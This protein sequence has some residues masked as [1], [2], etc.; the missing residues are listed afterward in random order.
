MTARILIIENHPDNQKLMGYLL[1]KS[2]YRVLFADSGEEGI[3][4]ALRE[5]F[6]LIL[7]DIRM[8]GMDGC[9]VARHLKADP[10]CQGTPLVAVTALT[11]SAEQEEIREAG[12]DGYLAKAIAPRLFI[13]QV[14]SFLP[15]G[16]AQLPEITPE[17][18]RFVEQLRPKYTASNS[19]RR[20]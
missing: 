19:G 2:G 1:E 15:G 17:L 11:G 12:F 8:S 16:I 4:L 9:D 14:R 20:K 13:E 18:S 7:C 10:K 6:D 3:D 5:H